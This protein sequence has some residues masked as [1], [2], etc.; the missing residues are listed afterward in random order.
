MSLRRRAASIGW[1]S[2]FVL[3]LTVSSYGGVHFQPVSAD[4]LKMTSEPLAPGAAAIILYHEVNRDDYGITNRGGLRLAG[5]ESAAIASRYEESY[6][7][8]KILTEAGRR[9]G[10]IEIPFDAWAGSVSGITARTIRPDGSIV[11]FSGQVLEQ[12]LVRGR[13]VQW[14]KKVFVMPDVQVGSIIEYFYTFNF[15]EGYFFSSSWILNEELFTKAAKFTLK[16]NHDDY[17]PVSFRWLEHLP[18]GTPSPKQNPDNSVHLEVT[19]VAAFDREDFMPPENQL[20]ARVDFIYSYDPF[21]NDP[22]K[23]WKKFGKRRN[24]ALEAFLGKRGSIDAAVAQIVSPND[25][26]DTKLRKLYARVQ[27]LPNRSYQA[28]TIELAERHGLL[29]RDDIGDKAEQK[30]K[31][32]ADG[33]ED[34]WKQG[35]GDST[36][37]NWLYL[38]MVRAAGVEA[39]GVLVS[40]RSNYFF[41]E[42]TMQ[43]DELSG[44]AV[45]AKIDGKDVYLSPGEA[46]APFGMLPW[47]QSGVAG[48]RLDKDGGTWIKTSLPGSTASKIDRKAELHL[49]PDGTLSGKLEVTFTGLESIT[50]RDEGRNLD[51]IARKKSIE[52]QVASWIPIAS[53]ITLTNQPDW[54]G[55]EAPL[56]A[57]FNLKVP[58]WAAQAGGRTLFPVGLFGA[59]E[60]HTFEYSN[61]TYPIYF[62]F[63]S[64]T[65]DD[66]NI[67]LPPNWQVSALPKLQSHDLHAV[68]CTFSVESSKTGLH[69]VRKLDVNVLEID[70][71]YYPALRSFYQQVKASDEQPAVLVSGTSSSGN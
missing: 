51:N 13:G 65:E 53:E 33:A 24:D 20:K 71:K 41:D 42:Q 16:P 58:G 45:L 52:E 5:E 9:Y 7:R 55:S 32:A 12:T 11:N 64:E 50:H 29:N 70:P 60:K 15:H 48:L 68:G 49:S 8:I 26:P 56:V 2:L 31:K 39:Y 4:E 18:V 69:L 61:R 10:N 40:E 17:N 21:E 46:Y 57:T 62:D 59:P 47:A 67:E 27:Q 38:A 37:L 23:Y 1:P 43:S 63:P 35:S 66:I 36:Q 22:V 54:T 34:V 19:N 6:F 44:T 25:S 14:R 28:R 30:K 3:L